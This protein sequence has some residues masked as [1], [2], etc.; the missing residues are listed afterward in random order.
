MR[1]KIFPWFIGGLLL[2]VIFFASL[3]SPSVLT[4]SMEGPIKVTYNAPFTFHFSHMMNRGSVETAFQIF[5]KTK[6]HFLWKDWKTLEFSP[7]APL[8]IGDH[9]RVVIKASAKSLWMKKIGFDTSLNYVVTGPP[10]VLFVNPAKD[11]VLTKNEPITVMFDRPMDWK[12]VDEKKLIQITPAVSGQIKFFGMS[13]LQFFPEKLS[14]KQTYQITIAGGLKALDGGIT[15]EDF[16]WSILGPSLHV[17]KSSPAPKAESVSLNEPIKIVF[18]EEA[19]LAAIKPG[20]NA[21]LYP[22]N[23]LDAAKK[24]KTDGF[25]NT[26][27]VYGENDAGEVQKNVL[28]FTPSFPYQPGETYRFVLKS[29]ADFPLDEDFELAFKTIGAESPP[30]ESVKKAE[31]PKHFSWLNGG[32]E[33]F[34]RGS[35]PILQLTEPIKEKAMLSACQISSNDFIHISAKN[36]WNDYKC[37]TD[38]V[39]L[40]P[41]PG[42]EIKLADHFKMDWITGVYFAS[43]IMNDQKLTKVFMMEDSTLLLKRSD[44]DL[45][46]WALDQK[47][48]SPLA[49]MDLEILDYDGGVIANGTTDDAGVYKVD[50]AFDEGIYVRGKKE[51]EGDLSRWGLVSDQWKLP[52]ETPS[53]SQSDSTFVTFLNQNTFLPGESLKIKGFART[54]TD[55]VLTYP[56]SRQVILEVTDSGQNTIASKNI[57]VPLNGS[58]DAELP[59]PE[60]SPVGSYSVTLSDINHQSLAPP[61]PIQLHSGSSPVRLEWMEAKKDYQAGTTPLFIAQ[62][63]YENGLPAGNLKGH[64]QLFQTP[65]SRSYQEGVFDYHFD[66]L[67]SSCEQPCEEK[68]L[69]KEGDVEF[70]L[71]GE[72][73]L[74]LTDKKEGFLPADYFYDLKIS[75]NQGEEQSIFLSNSFRLHQGS[76][77]VGLGLKHAIIQAD[78]N[79]ETSVLALS[80]QG[81][82]LSGKSIKVSLLSNDAETKTLYSTS[83]TTTDSPTSLSIH[84]T[85]E[86]KDGSYILQAESQDEKH[87]RIVAK[88]LVFISL[89]PDTA[90]SQEF[91]LAPDQT[92]YL[93]G[94]RAHFLVNEPSASPLHPVPV[95]VTYERDGLLSYESLILKSPITQITTLVNESMMPHFLAKVN[96]LNV[97]SIS[98]FST[99]SASIDV[100]NDKSDL[101]MDLSYEPKNPIPGQEV[102]LKIFAHDHQNF[103]LSSA[104]SVNVL[105]QESELSDFSYRSFFASGIKPLSSASNI[106]LKTISLPSPIESPENQ[107]IY[108]PSHSYYFNPSII[109]D[110]D[111]K[112]EVT[113]KLPSVRGNLVVQALATKGDAQ[114]GSKTEVLKMDQKLLIEPILPSFAVPGDQTVFSA[115]VKNFSDQPIHSRLE[116][117]SKDVGSGDSSKNFSLEP[118]QETELSFNVSVDPNSSKDRLSF[119]FQTGEDFIESSLP[120]HHLK[121][122]MEVMKAVF[123]GDTL[124]SRIPTPLN[125]LPGLDTMSFAVSASPLAIAQGQAKTMETSSEDSTYLLAAKLISDV[126]FLSENP[127]KN[128]LSKGRNTLSD[129]LKKQDPEGAYRFWN[130]PASS[131][132]LSALILFAYKEAT[133]HGLEVPSTTSTAEYLLGQLDADNLSLDDKLFILWVL[134]HYQ[135]YDTERALGYFEKRAE[136]SLEGRAFLLMNLHDLVLAGQ[137][138]VN[139]LFEK[140][141]AEMADDAIMTQAIKEGGEEENMVSFNDSLQTT[142][143]MLFALSTVDPGNEL[144]E[145]M[146]Y[147]IS[148]HQNDLHGLNP[149]ETL[150][151][152]LALKQFTDQKGPLDSHLITQIKL[153]DSTVMDHSITPSNAN[154][155]F[156]ASVDAKMLNSK[157]PNDIVVKRSGTDPLYLVAYLNSLLD[158]L[159]VPPTEACMVLVRTLYEVNDKG[160]K[161]PASTL[162]KGGHYVSKLDFII[163]K[164]SHYVVLKDELPAGFMVMPNTPSSNELFS[165]NQS[166]DGSLTYFSPF[167]PAGVYTVETE[168]RAVLPGTFIQLPASLSTMFEPEVNSRTVGGRVEIME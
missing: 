46:V 7:D 12:E 32:M 27:V 155:I 165:K 109:T 42:T 58:F 48:G 142:A 74:F 40:E 158:P 14:A 133:Q 114:F 68:N 161:I 85:S 24:K 130:E 56:T 101:L 13:A 111:G 47:S 116:F 60:D 124:T 135:Q 163:P 150:W 166:E 162:K 152:I 81:Q 119:R 49:N 36:G 97:G 19:P 147:F 89:N 139:G 154:D 4:E 84:L 117:I 76:Y 17:D 100:D 153:N 61:T 127:A 52:D 59:L 77:D 123:S 90:L 6:G 57:S 168:L 70:D 25:F 110:S 30:K 92:R 164:E 67:K 51:G 145:P 31:P 29:V 39:S 72:A 98:S 37:D 95:M 167:L 86:M 140:L 64:Y 65:F 128:D 143:I 151:T 44:T 148:S 122:S 129:L 69:V 159:A 15:K 118:G 3:S 141:K 2:V 121:T 18:N 80:D 23:D 88:K 96:R 105:N 91:F 45:F 21:L 157:G 83:T 26:E 102:T 136:A 146:T 62:A 131:P 55:H 106:S 73:Q 35:A 53:L 115:L 43:L 82:R 125:V 104:L 134:G 71:N 94:G 1:S 113:F 10:Y 108:H 54:Q 9:Y 20:V 28:I 33:F 99:A 103:P 132:L 144:L 137:K 78:G 66:G 120:L 126:S 50:K 112:A 16:S 107:E 38:P 138:S 22:S 79:I 63:R 41:G 93:V 34:P 87:N 11:S 156:Q 8:T 5:P 75:V 149:K 160:E